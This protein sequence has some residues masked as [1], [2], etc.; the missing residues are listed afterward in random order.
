M[1]SPLLFAAFV[2]WAS[3][4]TVSAI[5]DEKNA[6]QQD[7]AFLEEYV[8]GVIVLGESVDGP[9]IAVV[10]A[11]Q[12]RVMTS[13]TGG[14]RADSFGWI[15]Y[16]HIKSGVN[17]PHINVYGGEERFWM[18]PE[19]GQF[20][21]F[22]PPGSTFNLENWQTPAVI[23]T[24]PF[25]LVEQG[26]G[27]ALFR[28]EAQLTNYADATFRIRID[29]AI[30]LL[31][32]SEAERSLGSELEGVRMVGYRTRNKLTNIGYNDWQKDTGLLSIWILGMYKPG[33]QTT[34]V[35]PFRAG[36][37]AE[38]GPMVNDAY[39]GKPPGE[40]LKVGNG[41]L[42]FSGDG[43]FRSKIG[44]PP[45]RALPAAG[46]WDVVAGML[47]IVRF[48]QPGPDVTDYVNSMWELQKNP[49]AGDVVN[50]YNDGPPIPGAD[51]LGPFYELETSSPAL[52][53]KAGESEEHI[54][55]TYHF[56]GNR[57]ALDVL[58]K[59]LLGASLE[60]IET[61]LPQHSAPGQ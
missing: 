23:D 32:R 22:F 18:G 8:G 33:P 53:L 54:Q 10:P 34:V 11:Y 39:F 46:S 14:P 44:L 47:T 16:A 25:Q 28:H 55:E 5:A 29:R 17:S 21:I 58:A 26:T 50:A 7:V 9:Q 45:R 27:A 36:N 41:V 49:Y 20:S 43:A 2:S 37:D 60:Q 35:I 40:R 13:T 15:N 57:A 52:A 6:F 59:R 38:L 1:R 12:A 56:E 19:G 51:P 4:M 3:L 61:A 42:F 30:Q 31:S 24:D 48:N